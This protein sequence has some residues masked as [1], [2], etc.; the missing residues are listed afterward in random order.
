MYLMYTELNFVNF[1]K[2]FQIGIVLVNLLTF[3][4][5]ANHDTNHSIIIVSN[6]GK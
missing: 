5:A 4:I 3:H 6:Y 1:Q 2:S